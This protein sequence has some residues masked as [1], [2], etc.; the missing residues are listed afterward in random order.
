MGR[1]DT[2]PATLPK[3]IERELGHPGGFGG[4]GGRIGNLLGPY[5]DDPNEENPELR[6]PESVRCF[7]KMRRTDAQVAA[8]IRQLRFPIL[9]NNYWI[10]PNGADDRVVQ[11]WVEDLNL[12]VIGTSTTDETIVRSRRRGRFSFIKHL[13]QVFLAVVFGHMAFEIVGEVRDDVI[14]LRKLAPRM[15]QTLFRF[16]VAPDGGLRAIEQHPFMDATTG[17]FDTDP[18]RIPI[19]RLVVYPFEMEG[20]NWYGMSILRS[21]YKH[22]MLKDRLYRV[23][24]MTIERN[25]MGVPTVEGTQPGATPE[26][27]RKA[28]D[29]ATKYRAGEAAGG[30]IP[31]GFRLRLVGVEGSLPD[32]LPHIKHHDEAIAKNVLAMFMQLGST[33]TGSRALG[34]TFVESFTMS[35]QYVAN[36]AV[37]I[38]NMHVIEDFTDWN[39]G[40]DAPAPRIVAGQ[41]GAESDMPLESIQGLVESGAMSADPELE[42]YLRARGRIPQRA[43]TD[44]PAGTGYQYDLDYGI[45]TINERRAAIGL[46]PIPEGDVPPT[47]PGDRATLDAVNE[48]RSGRHLQPLQLSAVNVALRSRGVAEIELA[49]GDTVNPFWRDPTAA[50]L[51]AGTDFIAMAARRDDVVADLVEQIRGVRSGQLDEL[52]EQ[53]TAAVDADDIAALGNLTVTTGDGAAAIEAALMN[54]LDASTDAAIAEAANQGVRI[55]RPDLED[56]RALM[57][58]R[59][60]A[61][62]ELL[63]QALTEVA[64]R[65]SLQLAAPGID[66]AEVARQVREHIEGL[67][68]QWLTDQLGGTVTGAENTGRMAVFG[69][70]APD[71]IFASELLD[72]ATCENCADIDGTEYASVADA[73]ADYPTGGYKDCL[74]GPRCRGTII[75]TYGESAP[76]A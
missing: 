37:D 24:T 20:S 61:T 69:R 3:S 18:I 33:E 23:S 62:D 8:I 63:G 34:N 54:V 12:P 74:G 32:A 44:A 6:W 51:A 29:L 11:R 5:G 22:W 14:R 35:L 67:S 41:I 56:A 64:G 76:E 75:A 36:W 60:A 40:P 15:P 46:P 42:R 66:G 28:Q 26:G 38:F 9:R 19:E 45:I 30:Y 59:S 39:D 71:R 57:I 21:A 58:Q 65:R 73:E 47:P 4:G 17:R 13:E 53:I 48:M 1:D 70:T 49:D 31:F 16:D 2:A 43:E 55:A 72:P 7:D 27:E 25:G 52:V 10:D 68:D 50:E